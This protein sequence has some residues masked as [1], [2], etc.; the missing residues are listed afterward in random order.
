MTEIPFHEFAGRI[1]RGEAGFTDPVCL[2]YGEDFLVEQAAAGIIG[3]VLPDP[4]ERQKSLETVDMA[5]GESVYDIVERLNTLSFFAHRKVLRLKA[6]VLFASGF[7][8][9]DQ[10]EK[11][12]A[13]RLSD[14]I[15]AAAN[16]LAG[17]AAA[18]KCDIADIAS[19]DPATVLNLDPSPYTEAAWLKQ[20]AAHCAEKGIVAGGGPDGAGILK[21]AIER[22]LPKNHFLVITAA[23]VDRRTALYKALSQAHTVI[24]CA[25]APGTRKA[26]VDRQKQVLSYLMQNTLEKAGKTAD[27]D[28]FERVFELTGFAPR[29]FAGNIEK[30]A[31]YAG[32]NP[33]IKSGDVFAVLGKTREDPV[34]AFTGAVFEKNAQKALET[35]ASLTASGFHYMQL[36]AGIAGQ[37]RKLLMVKFFTESIHGSSWQPGMRYDRFTREVMEKV[38]QY[39]RETAAAAAGP[40]KT[41]QGP[42]DEKP[43]VEDPAAG[44]RSS[45]RKKTKPKTGG[46]AKAASELAIV[47]NPNN[48]YP[49][50]QLFL[51]ANRFSL[52]TLKGFMVR[53]HEADIRLKTT[54]YSPGAVLEELV[55]HICFSGDDASAK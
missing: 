48:P 50:Y 1:R 28:V 7:R 12:E 22:G 44:K 15:K 53:L 42:A 19:G 49:V 37:A 8:P 38:V 11:I 27:R 26:D 24:N 4:K 17:L 54:G 45:G 36:H 14:D 29:V 52:S 31:Q 13:A 10:L 30:L 33:R 3:A 34:F 9:V 32:G 40:A 2:V 43:A 18:Q 51:Q 21:E 46:R 23:A 47:K 25:V 20:A 41:A 16:L 35:M 39:D 6:D 5:D 55:L